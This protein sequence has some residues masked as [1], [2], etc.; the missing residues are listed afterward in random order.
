[1]AFSALKEAFLTNIGFS[2]LESIDA[3][4]PTQN[5]YLYPYYD[6]FLYKL[7]QYPDGVFLI[8][9]KGIYTPVESGNFGVFH[10]ERIPAMW[11]PVYALCDL[12]NCVVFQE[13][14][15][16]LIFQGVMKTKDYGYRFISDDFFIKPISGLSFS[17]KA[18]LAVYTGEREIR[19]TTEEIVEEEEYQN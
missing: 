2:Q 13:K 7:S 19:P 9:P 14:N 5:P 11:S 16:V 8:D 15:R 10:V 1:M 18:R 17:H 4:S 3:I 12:K 6:L